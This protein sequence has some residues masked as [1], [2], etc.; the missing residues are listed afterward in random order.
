MTAE[1][2]KKEYL[3]PEEREKYHQIYEIARDSL[4]EQ[5]KRIETL[6]KKAQINLVVIGIVLGFGLFKIEVISNLFS[7]ISIWD[8]VKSSQMIFFIISFFCFTFSLIFSI[9]ALFIRDFQIYP[10]IS[11]ILEKFKDKRTEDLHISMSSHFQK[12]IQE[13]EKALK[14]KINHLKRS[15]RLILAAFIFSILFVIAAVVSKALHL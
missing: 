1:E 2:K 8:I 4:V 12:S 6:E 15:I 7:A 11:Q 9:L 10:D 14:S 3:P 5:L 13:N